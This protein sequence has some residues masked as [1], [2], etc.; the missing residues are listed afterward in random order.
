VF[1]SLIIGY[2]ISVLPTAMVV[3]FFIG[4]IYLDFFGLKDFGL[5]GWGLRGPGR[6]CGIPSI[7]LDHGHVTFLFQIVARFIGSRFIC[8]FDISG[9]Y[10]LLRYGVLPQST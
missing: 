3:V 7:R 5:K 4:L 6:R 9:E 8:P 2:L 1:R 10:E